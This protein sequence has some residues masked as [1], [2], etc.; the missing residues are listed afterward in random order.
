MYREYDAYNV[1]DKQT[2]NMQ[3]VK[4]TKNCLVF[5]ASVKKEA[6]KENKKNDEKHAHIHVI[7][8]RHK[9]TIFQCY[10]HIFYR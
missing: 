9:G 2:T 1:E 3:R 4:K 5:W 7:Y 6:A 8:T 10:T